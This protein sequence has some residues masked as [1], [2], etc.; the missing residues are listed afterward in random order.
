MN[1]PRD[2]GDLEREVFCG[3]EIDTCPACEGTWMDE[4]EIARVVGMVKDMM[5]GQEIKI[6]PLP[7]R[8]P[9]EQLM[10]PRCGDVAMDPF[11]FSYKKELIVDRCRKC[12]G[13]WLDGGELKQVLSFAYKEYGMA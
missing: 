4:G 12:L 10:C 13:I 6:G 1:C 9:G 8:K 2:K 7:D 3:V 11:Y 5:D